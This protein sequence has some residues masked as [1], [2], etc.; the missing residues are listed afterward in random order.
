MSDLPMFL[1]FWSRGAREDWHAP[2]RRRGTKSV[3]VKDNFGST[4][5]NL[6]MKVIKKDE[7][8]AFLNFY[9]FIY[10]YWQAL[11]TPLPTDSNQT[12]QISCHSYSHLRIKLLMILIPKKS[13]EIT[14]RTG[15]LKCSL[16]LSGHVPFRSF[17]PTRWN[18][19]VVSW[20]KK[21]PWH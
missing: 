11:F 19:L 1:I 2:P 13:Y 20:K 6:E 18:C 14:S 3:E 7:R 4:V 16:P 21:S 10:L 12:F 5:P 9:L 17:Y 8:R 15:T